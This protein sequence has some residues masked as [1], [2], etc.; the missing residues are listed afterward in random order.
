MSCGEG[1]GCESGMFGCSCCCASVT[2]IK[3]GI[4]PDSMK[5]VSIDLTLEEA[6]A[7]QTITHISK[8]LLNEASHIIGVEAALVTIKRDIDTANAKKQ[9]QS[10]DVEATTFT[11]EDRIRSNI[12]VNVSLYTVPGW[13]SGDL[14][15]GG[16]G[17]I[18]QENGRDYITTVSLTA[19]NPHWISHEDLFGYFADGGLF[20]EYN[21]PSDQ[22]GVRI[23]VRYVPRLQFPPAYHDPL[24][25]MQHYWKC[26]RGE[27]EFLEGFYGGTNIPIPSVSSVSVSAGDSTPVTSFDGQP[28][29]TDDDFSFYPDPP[30]SVAEPADLLLDLYPNAAMAFS[31]RKLDKNYLGYAMRVREDSGD[32]E[33]YIGYDSSGNLD[34]AAIAA[35]CGT[36]NG[37]VSVWYDQSGNQNDAVQ[38]THAS[39]PQIYNGSAVLTEN[40]KPVVNF[41]S[42]KFMAIETLGV[43]TDG[44]YT[45]LVGGSGDGTN[46]YVMVATN[47]FLTS[48]GIAQNGNTGATVLNHTVDGYVIN[49]VDVASANQD[50][51]FDNMGT[52]GLCRIENHA[53]TDAT[54]RTYRLNEPT[55]ATYASLQLQEMV[56]WHGSKNTDASN[57]ESNINDY[58][59]I[60]DG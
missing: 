32:T 47:Y 4:H 18:D 22:Y 33:A 34:T 6:D 21:A 19:Q 37:Y 56:T 36:A 5:T 23:V 57:I 29:P 42:Q 26:S 2:N 38:R 59:G 55:L 15:K 43:T 35:H 28:Q 16:F 10:P 45:F 52:Q 49:T 24:D 3:G 53:S 1:C 51:L 60:Y 44:G 20:V 11:N 41:H 17:A 46:G 31:V 8:I 54:D 25:V 50:R 13:S 39:Q 27:A 12:P 40:G 48:A 7:S 58:F 30:S 9:I 14:N